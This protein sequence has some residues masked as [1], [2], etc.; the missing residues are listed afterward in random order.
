MGMH[1][2]HADLGSPPRF[3]WANSAADQSSSRGIAPHTH[4]SPFSFSLAPSQPQIFDVI[5]I[6]FN[7]YL[8]FWLLWILVAASELLVEAHEI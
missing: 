5:F 2:S 8:L 6:F 7:I 3:S 4:A 1:Q